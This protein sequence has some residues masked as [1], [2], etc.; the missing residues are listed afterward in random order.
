MRSSRFSMLDQIKIINYFK[1]VDQSNFTS[2]NSFKFVVFINCFCST[3][4]F[5]FSI[6]R[7]SK[8]SQYQNIA[9]DE[10]SN[11]QKFKTIEMQLFCTF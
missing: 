5:Y 11:Q 7:T 8:I 10:A 3:F 6:N 4:R 1:F 2:I 9:I